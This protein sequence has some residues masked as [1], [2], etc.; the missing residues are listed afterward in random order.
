MKNKCGERLQ[1]RSYYLRHELW[2]TVG[3]SLPLTLELFLLTWQYMSA[4]MCKS[5]S[6]EILSLN[7]SKKCL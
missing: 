7:L 2:D 1:V 4:T 3:I 6:L 5:L